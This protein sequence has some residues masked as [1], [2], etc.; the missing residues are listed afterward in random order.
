[1]LAFTSHQTRPTPQKSARKAQQYTACTLNGCRA[2]GASLL[3]ALPSIASTESTP[4]ALAKPNFVLDDDA[5]EGGV[6]EPP[7]MLSAR[8][9]RAGLLDIREFLAPRTAK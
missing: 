9:K 5:A 3:T 2:I 6:T 1:M 4:H 7:D 8:D